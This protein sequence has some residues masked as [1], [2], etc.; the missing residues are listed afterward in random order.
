MKAGADILFIGLRV[1]GATKTQV[2]FSEVG[3]VERSTGE[4]IPRAP[5]YTAED[6]ALVA[7]LADEAAEVLTPSQ[8]ECGVP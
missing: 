6:L 1:D 3:R 8:L 2:I 7:R 5:V 4:Q